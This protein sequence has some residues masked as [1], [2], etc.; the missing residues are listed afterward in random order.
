MKVSTLI[1][2]SATHMIILVT[3]FVHAELLQL[4]RGLVKQEILL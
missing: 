4:Q 2:L 1:V 3:H